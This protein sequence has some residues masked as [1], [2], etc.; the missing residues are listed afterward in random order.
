MVPHA[1]QSSSASSLCRCRS[2]LL[3]LVSPERPGRGRAAHLLPP[4]MTSQ[5]R[6][7]WQAGGGGRRSPPAV[8]WGDGQGQPR[9]RQPACLAE[10]GLWSSSS[11]FLWVVESHAGRESKSG[12]FYRGVSWVKGTKRTL[13]HPGANSKGKW[14]A[15]LEARVVAPDK[16]AGQASHA[17]TNLRKPRSTPASPSARPPI[18]NWGFPLAGPN[19][20]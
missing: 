2:F 18:P 13:L 6:E 15:Q 9:C 11:E 19:R 14:G 4:K 16:G 20:K 10:G 1:K 17:R 8:A 5:E 12:M 7:L 3:P